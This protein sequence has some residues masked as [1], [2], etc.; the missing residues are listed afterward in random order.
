MSCSPKRLACHRSS[1]VASRGS[2][3][4]L[5]SGRRFRPTPTSRQESR[6]TT[7]SSSTTTGAT[8]GL[9]P[10]ATLLAPDPCR[11]RR[12]W[13]RWR[14][15][16]AAADVP[17]QSPGQRLQDRQPGRGVRRA[18]GHRAAARDGV[19][20]PGAQPRRLDLALPPRP[21]RSVA[22]GRDADVR[23]VSC[24]AP[25]AGVPPFCRSGRTAS[26]TR[27]MGN[28]SHQSR[29]IAVVEATVDILWPPT[30]LPRNG[31]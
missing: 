2:S 27:E 23:V 30:A 13:W 24:P 17:R 12:R 6:G 20:D 28:K 4:W 25:G 22:D 16:T 18:A 5:A 19:G 11:V 3:A 9:V 14:W 8:A 31:C 7:T 29:R 15:S 10:E 1:T 21:D 26:T